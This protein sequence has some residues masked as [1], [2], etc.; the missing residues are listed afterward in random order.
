MKPIDWYVVTAENFEE[1]KTKFTE[2][3]GD[4]VFYAMSV[5]D[6]ERI[7]INFAD[8]LR[9]IEQQKQLIIYYEDAISNQ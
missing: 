2:Q 5:A 9:Y 3:N 4:F 8:V 6:Y 1:F 7:A